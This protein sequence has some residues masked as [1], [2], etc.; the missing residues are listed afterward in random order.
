[1]AFDKQAY[2]RKNREKVLARAKARY[3]AKKEEIRAYKKEYQ[4]RNKVELAAKKREHYEANKDAISAWHKAHYAANPERRKAASR[5][6]RATYPEKAKAAVDTWCEN[7]PERLREIK[8]AYSRQRPELGLHS[9]ARR[10]ARVANAFVERVDYREVLSASGGVCGICRN[11]LGDSVHFDHIIP[12][13]R[14]GT[15]ERANVQAAHPRCNAKKGS[16]LPEEL[17]SWL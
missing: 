5:A 1:M 12:L 17:T 15:H 9:A 2:Y 6:Y 14:G 10:R 11:P 16:K 13:A 3:E 7:N 4:Q 8:R